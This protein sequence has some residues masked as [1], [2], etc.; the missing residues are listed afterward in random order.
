MTSPLFMLL[1]A[2]TQ[3]LVLVYKATLFAFN[4]Q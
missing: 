3:N 4:V 2:Y 1:N